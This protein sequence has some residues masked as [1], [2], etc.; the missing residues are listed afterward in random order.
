MY[1]LAYKFSTFFR[2]S[3]HHISH[4]K[5][6][7]VTHF[8]ILPRSAPPTVLYNFI[9]L[10]VLYC[11]HLKILLPVLD[12]QAFIKTSQSYLYDTYS[13]HT[14]I[15]NVN[16]TFFLSQILELLHGAVG[17]MKSQ[18]QAGLNGNCRLLAD[19]LVKTL[20]VNE[21]K[22]LILNSTINLRNSPPPPPLLNK[23]SL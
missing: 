2:T 20:E 9:N 22:I 17:M 18:H 12:L 16:H 1:F 4:P 10:H 13:I 11:K 15:Y 5:H 3:T 7:E 6:E 19:R 8:N 14:H 23:S 21:G